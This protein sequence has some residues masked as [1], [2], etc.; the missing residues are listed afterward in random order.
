MSNHFTTAPKQPTVSAA[1]RA[2]WAMLL[3]RSVRQRRQHLG[4]SVERA[5]ELSGMEVSDWYALEAGWVPSVESGLLDAIAGTLEAC[6]I[7]FP[8]MAEISRYN[9]EL[10]FSSQLPLAS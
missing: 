9:Q 7:L 1:E 6:H 5:A 10:L 3:A 2:D 8:L 4:L